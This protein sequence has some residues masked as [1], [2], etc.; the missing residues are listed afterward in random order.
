MG[1]LQHKEQVQLGIEVENKHPLYTRNN[2]T[3]KSMAKCLSQQT[4]S[5]TIDYNRLRQNK[6]KSISILHFSVTR[7]FLFNPQLNLDITTKFYSGKKDLIL[8][9][10]ELQRFSQ[11]LLDS[12]NGKKIRDLGTQTN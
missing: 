4:S 7:S 8:Q 10:S 1:I 2:V 12:R 11:I 9:C 6:I 3:P 5:T